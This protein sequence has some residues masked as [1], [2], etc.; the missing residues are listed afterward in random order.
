MVYDNYINVPFHLL[1]L[2][3]FYIRTSIRNS[4]QAHLNL[5]HG[6]LLDVGCGAMPY[7]K[8]I[9]QHSQVSE[10]HGIDLYT[11][12]EYAKEVK[13]DYYWDGKV[14]PFGDNSF[15]VVMMTE[16]LEHVPDPEAVLNEVFRVLRKGGIIFL[17]IPFLWPLHEVPHDEYRF[18]PFAINRILDISGFSEIHIHA[19]GGWNASLAQMLGLWVRRS[20]L[21]RFKRWL[22]SLLLTPFIRY[23][24]SKDT[25]PPDFNEGQMI[26]GLVGI[27]QK[28]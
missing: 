8:Y 25:I 27:A 14:L 2:D 11:A 9:L 17:T 13:P 5:F 3:R 1:N 22:L 23:L 16:V 28:G 24:I 7:K 21:S 10:Y 15:D 19:T 20:A 4:L 6:M 12:L 26:T 18:T